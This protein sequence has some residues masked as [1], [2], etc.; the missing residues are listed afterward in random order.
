MLR[1]VD[2]CT[3]LARMTLFLLLAAGG[4][5]APIHVLDVRDDVAKWKGPQQ[6]VAEAPRHGT[7]K[8]RI[9][10]T[11]TMGQLGAALLPL[12]SSDPG[13]DEHAL[14]QMMERDNWQAGGRL[15]RGIGEAARRILQANLE[16][17][18]ERADVEL[19][20]DEGG[21]YAG[22][23][24]SHLQLVL[25][26]GFYTRTAMFAWAATN[27]GGPSFSAS[28]TPHK[29][30]AAAHLAW[31]LPL[32]LLTFPL[33][34][35]IAQP[36][37]MSIYKGMEEAKTIEAIDAASA[38]LAAQLAGAAPSPTTVGRLP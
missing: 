5:A 1:N 8:V 26:P 34:L 21:A 7:I 2:R 15:I 28:A 12:S 37:F 18:Y 9:V 36:I 22:T 6:P 32:G 33:G 13:D 23:T 24:I 38:S 16:R 27:G 25:I 35:A 19:S 20:A 14:R 10:G 29:A 30:N 17:Y 4:C 31:A 11:P 3:S